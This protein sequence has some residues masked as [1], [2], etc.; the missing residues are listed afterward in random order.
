MHSSIQQ[1]SDNL[2]KGIILN[3]ICNDTLMKHVG[4]LSLVNP[5]GFASNNSC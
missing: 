2:S 4:V 5:I 1:F 3:K